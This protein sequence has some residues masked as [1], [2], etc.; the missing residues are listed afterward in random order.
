VAGA[1]PPSRTPEG[2]GIAP[3]LRASAVLGLPRLE[4][5]LFADD[6]YQAQPMPRQLPPALVLHFARARLLPL[7][8]AHELWKAR[9]LLGFYSLSEGV[10][11]LAD[12]LRPPERGRE[13]PERPVPTLPQKLPCIACA[14]ELGSPEQR[15]LA[16]QEF[17]RALADP[18][19][20][21]L[22][23]GILLCLGAIE[24]PPQTGPVEVRIDGWIR[25]H[26]TAGESFQ[27]RLARSELQAVKTRD[28]L[29]TRRAQETKA[30]IQAL[31]P[32]EARIRALAEVYLQLEDAIPAHTDG[33]SARLLRALGLAP[34][35]RE[36]VIGEFRQR[37]EAYHGS[38]E[39]DRETAAYAELDCLH[40]L[41]FFGVELSDEQT[42]LLEASRE[43]P[44]KLLIADALLFRPEHGEEEE[45]GAE[46]PEEA[47]ESDEDE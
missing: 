30:R 27:A 19:A 26:E 20:E 28:L 42:A 13:E 34:E 44:A 22:V 36:L 16:A 12:H 45:E 15:A 9:D 17:G 38:S 43:H 10:P 29:L 2:A 23:G 39:P 3:E 18:E 47:P 6:E 5:Y 24:P 1:G 7:L 14:G 4:A 32:G 40:A 25:A 41:T 46:V 21:R 35:T 8:G 33:W 31:P 11:L 37:A